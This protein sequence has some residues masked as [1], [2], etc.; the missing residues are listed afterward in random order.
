MFRVFECVAYE[1]DLRLLV[2]AVMVC[3]LFTGM[4][5]QIFQR[6][7]WARGEP[8]RV[9]IFILASIVGVGAWATHFVA[10]L[11]FEPGPATGYDLTGTIVSLAFAI[12]GMALALRLSLTRRFAF[13]PALGGGLLGVAIGVMHYAGMAAFHIEGMLFWDWSLIAASFVVGAVCCAAALGIVHGDR[14]LRRNVAGVVLL[15]VGICGL[16]LIGMSAVTVLPDPTMQLPPHDLPAP[17]VAAWVAAGSVLLLAISAMV[18]GLDSRR[19]RQERA[20]LR[21]LADATIE[22]LAICDGDIIVTANASLQK[23]LGAP[24]SAIVGRTLESFVQQAA[25]PPPFA[26]TAGERRECLVRG[27]DGEAIPVV[28]IARALTSRGGPRLAVA[29]RDLRD[30]IAADARLIQLA[31]TDSLTG[32]LNRA[33][34]NERLD[35]EY[36]LRRR[37]GEAFAVLALD[38]DRFKQV[39]DV[40][41]H[42]AGDEVLRTVAQR[43][44]AVLGPR[45]VIARLGGDEF[46]VLVLDAATPLAI[47]ALCEKILAAAT[48]EIDLGDYRANIGVSIG[49]S[50]FPRDAESTQLLMRNADAALYRAKSNGRGAYQFFEAQIGAKLRSRQMLEVD[51]RQALARGELRVVYQPQATIR[52]QTVFGFEA[53]VRWTSESRGEISPMDFIPI[54]EESGLI[55]TIGQWVLR[56]ACTEAAGWATPLQIAVNLSAVQLRSPALPA[57]IAEI[58]TETGLAA[59]RLEL[60]ITETA[61]IQD[62]DR[63]LNTLLKVKALGVKV[64]MDDFGTGYSS[65]SNLRAF[66]F[67]K[68]KIDKSFIHGVHANDQAAAIVRAIVGM[69]R[70]MNLAV[71]AEGVESEQELAF[72]QRELCCE[73]Q[74]YLF[75]KPGDIADFA[76]IVGRAPT[77]EPAAPV[78]RRA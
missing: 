78:L 20:R 50:R 51:L 59:N 9:W 48:P 52:D 62:F 27:A 40:F 13:A 57:L 25:S 53:L 69:G 16:H 23:L 61:L 42:A 56:Q 26:M 65:M 22:G 6:M 29:V 31:R 4:A 67:D 58:L 49:I 60:E 1:H 73:A 14:T 37:N 70:G 8:S 46:A 54:A 15:T 47:A 55:L 5:M 10:M 36:E 11:A 2:L 30:R 71:L 77:A 64:A 39:N 17:M 45:N 68:I 34:F 44:A 41:G 24:R 18:I 38:L 19:S 75:G 28:L 3:I 72:L 21:E 33:S 63:A 74:G 43:I 35:Q 76:D 12:A 32:L 66:P 7:S